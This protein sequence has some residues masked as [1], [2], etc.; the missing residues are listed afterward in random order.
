MFGFD[1][2][3]AKY[4]VAG[5]NWDFNI[6]IFTS[7]PADILRDRFDLM[8]GM[9]GWSHNDVMLGDNRGS[10][11]GDLDANLSFD[12]HVLNA[13]GIDRIAGL[14]TWL[15]GAL[16]TLFG[17]GAT[18]YR[19]GNLIMGGGGADQMMGRGGFDILDGDAWLNVRI[20]I[21]V[22]GTEYSAESLNSA[23]AAAGPF[24][25]KVYAMGSD[26]RPDF[27]APAFGGRSL[28]ALLLDRTV[29]P[30]NM[31][32]VR[33]IL[34]E[35]PGTARDTAIFAGNVD[36]YV[37]E[38]R[39]IQLGTSP[40]IQAAYDVNGDGFISVRDLGGVGRR[41][42]DDTDLIRNIEDLRFANETIAIDRPMGINVNLALNVQS[43]PT[44]L[45]ANGS[46]IGQ[47]TAQGIAGTFALAAG[48]SPSFA[49]ASD[50]TLSVVLPLGVNQ[51][52][53]LDVVFTTGG[54]SRTERL[55]VVT[56]SNA[57]NIV[58]GSV[59]DDL[60]YGLGS[61]DVIT[62]GDGNDVLFGQA[63][64]DQLS[65]GDRRDTLAGGAGNDTI[66]G[67]AGDDLI[68]FAWGDGNDAVDGGDGID[69][70]AITGTLAN[71]TLTATWNGAVLTALAGF[72]SRVSVEEIHVD[73]LGSAD[74]LAYA[75]AS[76]GVT[77]DLAAGTASGFTAIA[78]IS[79]V[80]GGG[81]ADVL[82]GDA[83]ANTLNGGGG[84]DLLLAQADDA[85]DLYIGGAGFDRLDLSAHSA[86]LS[87][88][89]SFSVA[90]VTGTGS[91]LLRSDRV[92]AVEALVF[93]AGNDT[94]LGS[95][96]ANS[97]AGGGGNDTLNGM[98]GNDTL[99]G[100]SGDDR[101]EGGAGIDLL[102]GGL[103]EDRFV[104]A[105]VSHSSVAGSDVITDFDLAGAPGGDLIDI[106]DAAG[107]PFLFIGTAAFAAGGTNQ[108]RIFD[109]G[110][111]TFVQLDTDTDTGAEAQIRLLG[112]HNLGAADFIL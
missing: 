89:L 6:P 57:V 105:A 33:E 90:T 14:R 61:N 23:Q 99:D 28:T 18:A 10:T 91:T 5:A 78:N 85:G 77:A 40:L 60:V 25:G 45:P 88:D 58:A 62:G 15:G 32:I 27:S 8:E 101:L 52:H 98:N 7:A 3:S 29:N 71:Q 106:G 50:G 34:T 22:N 69:R 9:S 4:D 70:I 31:S 37:I 17:A 94:A 73:L 72:T 43:A 66:S 68:L 2:A 83:G 95:G 13:A 19:D 56:G 16:E 12:D 79:N 54:L 87:V 41:A 30:G 112:L 111:D 104:F 93:G 86:D 42:F 82:S 51:A 96:V 53:Q 92:L 81:G 103:G 46:V 21:M 76:A 74:T 47:M 24:A 49:M 75:A 63:G 80:S 48:S 110:T 11:L 20:R 1:W 100:G 107:L 55:Q 59:N 64:A 36:E 35:A 102:T 97:L 44:G 108:V 39:G 26:G 38:G 65:G 84:A 109:N 67:G